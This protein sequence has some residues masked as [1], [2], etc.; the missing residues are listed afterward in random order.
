MGVLDYQLLPVAAPDGEPGDIEKAEKSSVVADFF[1]SL[2]TP[3][4][5]HV[6]PSGASRQTLDKTAKKERAQTIFGP[7]SEIPVLY[8][9]FETDFRIF[10]VAIYNNQLVLG[11]VAGWGEIESL[12]VVIDNEDEGSSPVVTTYTGTTSQTADATLAAAISGY[13]DTLVTT[14]DST[15]YGIAYAVVVFPQGSVSGWPK[16]KF[17][18]EGKKVYDHRT[19]ATVYS[20]NPS[21]CLADFM[22]SSIYGP[23]FTMDYAAVDDAADANDALVLGEKRRL[24]GL[25]LTQRQNITDWIDTLRTY[26]GCMVIRNSTGWALVPNRPRSVDR[27]YVAGEHL[28]VTQVK[29]L[30]LNNKPTVVKVK[31]TDTSVEPWHERT[32]TAELAGVTAGTL[33]RRESVIRLPGIQRYSQALREATERLNAATL[34]DMSATVTMFDEALETTAG[35]RITLTDPGTG[36]SAQNFRVL[37]AKE[38]KQGRWLLSLQQYDEDV[39]SDLVESPDAVTP[40]DMPSPL[41]PP[42]ITDLVL[43]EELFQIQSGIWRSRIRATWTGVDYPYL[44]YYRVD[45]YINSVLAETHRV[46]DVTWATA[47]VADGANYQI[48]VRTVSRLD[49]ASDAIFDTL[50]AQGKQLPPGDVP[51][52]SG[53]EVGGEVRLSWTAAI[54]IDIWRYEVRYGAAGVTWDNA[55]V[56]DRV[57]ALRLVTKEIPAGTWDVLV[58]A[59]DS[60]RQYS[61]AEARKTITVTVDAAAFLIDNNEFDT[62]TTSNMHKSIVGR[63]SPVDHYV[64]V[65]SGD[66]WASLFPLAMSDYTDPLATYHGSVSTEWLSETWDV[67]SV[68]SGNWQCEHSAVALSGSFTAQI[69]LSE[70]NVSWDTYTSM[71]IKGKGRYARVRITALTTSTLWVA[72]PEVTLRLD[73]VPREENGED[74]SSATAAKT[75]TLDREYTAVKNLT[76]QPL[77]SSPRQHAVDNLVMGDPS[78]FDAYIFDG[79]GNQIAADFRWHFEGV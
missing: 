74:T 72:V 78:S 60:V 25:A 47:E 27:A 19:P 29:R 16:I 30:D 58:K 22:S 65:D 55:E 61:A 7:G 57:D 50:T 17:R 66:T 62:P 35:D 76:L 5:S 10:A 33:A 24:I 64:T 56:I 46:Q 6:I 20:D 31:Y 63:V 3:S 79:D 45:V 37:E 42:Q 40:L 67:G 28:G 15:D 52:L 49:A 77:G 8:G 43:S 14:I 34:T 32:A 9:E 70:D 44:A 36:F 38:Q 21:L 68:V 39:Y 69:E 4:A 54:D 41:D 2:V 23:G 11:G 75:I 26:S 73:A 51:S 18:G 12:E 59:I 71:S 48:E 1:R 13:S 53:F